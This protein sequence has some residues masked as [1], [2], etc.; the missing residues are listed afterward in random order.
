MFVVIQS[1][2]SKRVIP[3]CTM[4]NVE[5]D[6]KVSLDSVHFLFSSNVSCITASNDEVLQQAECWLSTLNHMKSGPYTEI[7]HKDILATFL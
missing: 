5:Q 1:V 6:I 4:V 3:V 2:V 7:C